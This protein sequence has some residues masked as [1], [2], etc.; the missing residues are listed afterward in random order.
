MREL[1]NSSLK[2]SVVTPSYNQG[3]YLEATVLSVLR[4]DYPNIE[5]RVLDGGSTD[6][7]VDILKKYGSRLAYWCSQ[8]D[9]GQAQ[10]IANGFAQSTGDILCWLNSDDLFLPGALSAVA[11]CFSA[12][13]EIET[14]SGGAYVIDSQ[15]RPIRRFGHLR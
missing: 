13:P 12:H 10:A 2:I 4:Q 1:M 14:V 3:K 7:S 6:G 8:K 15:G 9:G 11:E 5:Y